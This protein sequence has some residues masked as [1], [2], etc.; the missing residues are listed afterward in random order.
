MKY[1]YIHGFGTKGD[2]ENPKV[3][4][5]GTIGESFVLDYNSS[6]T[7]DNIEQSLSDQ[8]H[9]IEDV[10]MVLVGTSLGAYWAARMAMLFSS[11]FVAINPCIDPANSL[12]KY[13][14]VPEKT[15]YSYKTKFAE[16]N[17]CSGLILLDM[18]DELFDSSI[19]L[20][21][22]KD[23]FRVLTYEGGNHRFQH[24]YDAL[25]DIQI[26]ANNSLFH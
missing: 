12:A 15:L 5:L 18:G 17:F 21:L 6:D 7:A 11:S 14:D 4:A 19:A 22:Y 3:K 13:P 23:R 2:P 20:K 26:L 10:E 24:I 9:K 1:I 8:I 16:N 25:P